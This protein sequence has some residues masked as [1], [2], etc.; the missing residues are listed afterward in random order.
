[1]TFSNEQFPENHVLVL[2]VNCNDYTHFKMMK[3]QAG[4]RMSQGWHSRCNHD[5]INNEM[6]G[7]TASI[8][9]RWFD[10]F[11][12]K[13]RFWL[14]KFIILPGPAALREWGIDTPEAREWTIG[15]ADMARS[16][17]FIVVNNNFF[18]MRT[19]PFQ[20]MKQTG[21][22]SWHLGESGKEGRLASLWHEHLLPIA[23]FANHCCFP[24]WTWLDRLTSPDGRDKVG[25]TPLAPIS[26]YVDKDLPAAPMCTAAFASQEDETMDPAEAEKIKKEKEAK[27]G[28]TL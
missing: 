9:H 11:S 6:R 20:V 3:D 5:G 10:T 17:G 1:M 14:K 7:L 8:C 28:V 13:C 4:E 18:V 27:E 23:T 2:P 16:F 12:Q 21:C 24:R 19:K 22:D 15:M 25:D 26:G